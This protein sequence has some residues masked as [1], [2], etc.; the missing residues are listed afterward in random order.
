MNPAA[1][2]SGWLMVLV[3]AA[4]HCSAFSDR[5][6][7]ALIAP[8]L[9]T[10]LHFSDFQIGLLQGTA[11]VV[12]YAFASI[13]FGVI[14]D[15]NHRFGIIIAGLVVW[16]L[17]TISFGL[18][19]SFVAMFIARMALGLGQAVLSPSALSLI[20]DA[21]PE[22]RIGRAISVYTTGSTLGR[23]LALLGGAGLLVSLPLETNLPGLG[24]LTPWRMVFLIAVV[25]NVF[26]AVL[27]ARLPEPDR[28]VRGSLLADQGLRRWFYD[29]RLF[30]V[31]HTIASTAIVIA[32]QTTTA[33]TTS[34]FLRRFALTP[35]A[36]G[37]L[38]GLIILVAAPLGH[39]GGGV[40][41][42]HLR[43]RW[44]A[45]APGLI[46][47]AALSSA[48]LLTALFCSAASL[49]TSVAALA[50]L[51]FVLGLAAPAGFAGIQ[52]MTPKHMQGRATALFLSVV[53][54]CGFGLGPPALGALTDNVFGASG[55]GLALI[56]I[57]A[58]AAIVGGTAIAVQMLGTVSKEPFLF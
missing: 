53:S 39:I 10:V 26:L 20:T 38:F 8:T 17:A 16:S 13:T 52:I 3:L 32:I 15:R 21:I 23:S 56:A 55:I 51:I 2:R 33:W 36:S 7:I 28:R 30:Y 41:L 44:A 29:H 40:L 49:P 47:L 43:S 57:V 4:T 5:L 54:V 9:K 12:V 1:L 46:I 19:T 14:V 24:P 48:S 31:T 11:F 18:G 35:A 25:P 42:D 34:F 37:T 50:G 27:I 6:L 58:S 45:R 22:N